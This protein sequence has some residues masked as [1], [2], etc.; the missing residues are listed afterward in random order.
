MTDLFQFEGIL[1]AGPSSESFAEFYRARVRPA[2][3]ERLASSELYAAYETW[4]V[5]AGASPVSQREVRTFMEANGHPQ[6]KSSLIYYAGAQLGDFAGA[7]LPTRRIAVRDPRPMR[8]GLTAIVAEL[9]ALSAD[10]QSMRRRIARL[11][12]AEAQPKRRARNAD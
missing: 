10:L 1:L 8:E 6:R 4:C 2:D 9:D 5:E 11:L 12:A 3:G 7:P